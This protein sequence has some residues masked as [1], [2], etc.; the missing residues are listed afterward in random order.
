MYLDQNGF[1][2]FVII[3]DIFGHIDYNQS[4]NIFEMAQPQSDALFYTRLFARS[5]DAEKCVNIYF[6]FR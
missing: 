3:N 2:Y 6:R 5:C 1:E 4:E